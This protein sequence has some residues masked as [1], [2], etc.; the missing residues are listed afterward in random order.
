MSEAI[1]DPRM[2]DVV[3]EPAEPTAE[4]PGPRLPTLLP[5]AFAKRFGAVIL[6]ET[7][8]GGEAVVATRDALALT[9]LAEIRR[10]IGKPLTFRSVAADEFEELVTTTYSRDSSEARQMVEDMGPTSC[11]EF[12]ENFRKRS[13]IPESQRL[14]AV[15]ARTRERAAA[16][17]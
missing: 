14:D 16:P 2:T 9:T 17:E 15:L 7:G 12:W 10:Y 11:A 5:F 13:P 6:D 8:S 3:E 1:S 4:H